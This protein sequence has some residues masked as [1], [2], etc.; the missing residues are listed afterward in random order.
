V[1]LGVVILIV[2]HNGTIVI[3][4]KTLEPIEANNVKKESIGSCSRL[5]FSVFL[6]LPII[7]LFLKFP[8]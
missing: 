8:Y 7:F 5:V 6:V 1:I 2:F 4:E 3:D